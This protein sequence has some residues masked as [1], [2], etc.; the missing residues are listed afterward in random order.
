MD[1]GAANGGG[2]GPLGTWAHRQTR[3]DRGDKPPRAK[4]SQPARQPSLLAHI[5]GTPQEPERAPAAPALANPASGKRSRAQAGGGDCGAAEQ[6]LAAAGG[7]R[8]SAEESGDGDEDDAA[9]RQAAWRWRFN[10]RWVQEQARQLDP[11]YGRQVRCAA[12]WV[13][14]AVRAEREYAIVAQICSTAA[15][16]WP[17][18]FV[19]LQQSYYPGL[20]RRSRPSRSKLV[21]CVFQCCPGSFQMLWVGA[22][23]SSWRQHHSAVQCVDA[24]R[25]Y[26]Q[27]SGQLS[28]S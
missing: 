20:P 27:L 16:R 2:G 12:R 23:M 25:T 9:V 3:F 8:E 21:T 1:D 28:A 10:R 13:G 5:P 26:S 19:V 22:K 7:P 14:Q 24:K 6:A 4:S 11:E 18:L 17:V 15:A